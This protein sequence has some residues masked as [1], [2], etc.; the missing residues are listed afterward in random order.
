M[1][2][3]FLGGVQ[4]LDAE[5]GVQLRLDDVGRVG[6]VPGTVG[7]LI[8]QADVL[9][10]R[11]GCCDGR[12]PGLEF[13]GLVAALRE[14]VRDPLAYGVGGRGGFVER[15]GFSF[16]LPAV[17]PGMFSETRRCAVGESG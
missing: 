16:D 6:E 10:G 14:L 15:V 1:V 7:Q 3:W 9:G 11:L 4:D 8:E 17:V 13:P 5:G 12:S 2:A